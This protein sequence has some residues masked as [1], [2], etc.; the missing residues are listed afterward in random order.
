MK[1]TQGCCLVAVMVVLS[2]VAGCGQKDGVSA[3]TVSRI[4]AGNQSPDRIV[5]TTFDYANS[6]FK[7][8]HDPSTPEEAGDDFALSGDFSQTPTGFLKLV[9][10]SST[11][12]NIPT[13]GSVTSYG[14]EVPGAMLI[15]KPFVTMGDMAV[16]AYQGDCADSKGGAFNWIQTSFLNASVDVDEGQSVGTLTQTGVESVAL[17]LLPQTLSRNL[18]ETSM[19]GECSAGRTKLDGRGLGFGSSAGVMTIGKAGMGGITALKQDE[20]ITLEKLSG[21]YRGFIFKPNQKIQEPVWMLSRTEKIADL[22]YWMNSGQ[23]KGIEK[24]TRQDASFEIG[25]TTMEKGAFTGYYMKD[26]KAQKSSV[27]KGMAASVGGK[28]VII[29]VSKQDEDGSPAVLLLV[30]Q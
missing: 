19:F 16:M 23:E 4:Y 5:S 25:F 9:V 30:S 14:I 26:R 24:D 18:S 11:K 29:A 10:R 21:A 15:A 12:D 28:N 22:G 8:V 17:K 20:T 27:L 6:T 1:R 13:D 2:A 3:G 7:M